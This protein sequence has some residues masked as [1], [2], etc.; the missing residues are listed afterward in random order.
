M[1][2]TNSSMSWGKGI[3]MSEYK[4]ITL[5]LAEDEELAKYGIRKT[6]YENYKVYFSIDEPERTVYILRV[7]HMLVDSREKILKFFRN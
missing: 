6:Y 2:V 7:F 4:M 1:T 3:P 5:S